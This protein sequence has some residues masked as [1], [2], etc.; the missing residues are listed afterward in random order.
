M[1]LLSV[2]NICGVL[3]V[4]CPKYNIIE[5]PKFIMW[6]PDLRITVVGKVGGAASYPLY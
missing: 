4:E 5:C 2:L 3:P 6:C 1:K